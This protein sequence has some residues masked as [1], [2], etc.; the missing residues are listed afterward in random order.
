MDQQNN[1]NIDVVRG[2]DVA[3]PNLSIASIFTAARQFS[4][5][6]YLSKIP[7]DDHPRILRSERNADRPIELAF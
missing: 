1:R 7:S 4:D 3:T 5:R 2:E 6:I